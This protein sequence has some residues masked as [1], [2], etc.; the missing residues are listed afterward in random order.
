MKTFS[1]EHLN[2][3]TD[4]DPDFS[5]TLVAL[6]LKTLDRVLSELETLSVSGD[7]K[8]WKEK[9]HELKGASANLGG[10]ALSGLCH[11]A[12]ESG[13]KSKP[14]MLSLIK[15]ESAKLRSELEAF[16]SGLGD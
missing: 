8:S 9:A 16:V 5:Q 1:I 12:E 14:E 3:V 10:E 15:A 2:N 11:Q 4:G 6:F 13:G 7:E